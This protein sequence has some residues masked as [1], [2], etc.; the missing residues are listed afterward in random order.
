M[1]SDDLVCAC[2][3][4]MHVTKYTVPAENS[5]AAE[6]WTLAEGSA[7]ILIL[8]GALARLAKGRRQMTPLP[9]CVESSPSE[10]EIAHVQLMREE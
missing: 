8:S 4:V 10:G 1:W 2:L 3:G 5:H 6:A 9:S 7:T